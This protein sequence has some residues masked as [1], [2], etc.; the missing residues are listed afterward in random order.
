MTR[1]NNTKYDILSLHKCIF[2]YEMHK[3][4]DYKGMGN[5]IL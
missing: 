4:D 3:K 2:F 5:Y 1:C